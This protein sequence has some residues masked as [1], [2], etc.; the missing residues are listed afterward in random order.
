MEDN[1]K[2]KGLKTVAITIF[3]LLAVTGSYFAGN[4]VGKSFNKSNSNITS[5]SE[6]IKNDNKE[7]KEL[8]INSRLV[9]KLYRSVTMEEEGWS[10]YWMYFDNNNYRNPDFDVNTSSEKV[11]MKL[12]G[13]NLADSQ[14]EYIYGDDKSKVPDNYGDGAYSTFKANE[15]GVNYGMQIGYKK[16][17]IETVYK[18]LFGENAK[19]DT[20]VE[21]NM[22]QYGGTVFFYIS[23]L[24]S[25]VEYHRAVGGTSGPGGYEST[26][27][28][29]V[30]KDGQIKIYEDVTLKEYADDAAVQNETPE[31]TQLTNVYTFEADSDGLFNF[32]S[33]KA[34]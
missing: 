28:K 29:A 27:T 14:K 8:D 19:L 21:I 34:E 13:K 15:N 3:A 6:V 16:E 5:P 22:D 26:L 25:Y 20:S 12:V 30:Y 24:D 4:Y 18:E 11:K 23:A 31:V 32:I 7:E 1:K 33:K 10:K 9:Q 2:G 17:Y